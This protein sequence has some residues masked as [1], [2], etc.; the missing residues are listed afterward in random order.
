MT[1]QEIVELINSTL[2]GRESGHEIQPIE[3][4]N[5]ANAV[6]EYAHQVEVTGQSILQGFAT[7]STVPVTLDDAKICYIAIC[8][9]NQTTTFP[10]FSDGNGNPI[11]VTCAENVAK[12][13]VLL[14]NTSYWEKLEIAISV[15]VGRVIDGGYADNS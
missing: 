10:S 4:Q 14:W 1:Y 2:V 3:H 15:A 9:S 7:P 8:D 6:L 5:I 13:V 11:S 12:V